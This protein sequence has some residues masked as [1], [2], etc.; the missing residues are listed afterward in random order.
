MEA[1]C[2]KTQVDQRTP[3][4][5]FLKEEFMWL[6][7]LG[8]TLTLVKNCMNFHN[9]TADPARNGGSTEL[10]AR[11]VIPLVHIQLVA[12]HTKSQIFP[13]YYSDTSL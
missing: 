5:H 6:N 9:C 8:E 13:E 7:C 10:L 12:V 4:P 11:V 2:N 3:P 1:A